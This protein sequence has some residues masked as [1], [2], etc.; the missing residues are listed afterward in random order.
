MV[1][2]NEGGIRAGKQQ[3]RR[4]TWCLPGWATCVRVPGRVGS[5]RAGSALGHHPFRS[6]PLA[7]LS[8]LLSLKSGCKYGHLKRVIFLMREKQQQQTWLVTS[9]NYF[10]PRGRLHSFICRISQVPGTVHLV[11]VFHFSSFFFY[12][13]DANAVLVSWE[14]VKSQLEPPEGLYSKDQG[15]LG[16]RAETPVI[17]TFLPPT[18]QAQK[19]R[20]LVSE[21][22]S[23]L[24]P[25][26]IVTG[27]FSLR[28]PLEG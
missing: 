11:L 1:Q 12:M 7:P 6:W 14:N 21:S 20:Y 27:A 26:I 15:D 17:L 22:S 10:I 4:T 9:L 23:N 3:R 28:F 16:K 2:F 8:E 24:L 5:T 19:W 25:V 18:S 13:K